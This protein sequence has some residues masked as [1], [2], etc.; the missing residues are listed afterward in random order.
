V[1]SQQPIRV[2]QVVGKMLGGGVE[3]VVMNYYRHTDRRIV[4]FD[5]IVDEDSTHVPTEEIESLGGRVIMVPPYQK[6]PAYLRALY[7]VFLDGQYRLVHSHINTLS[8]FPLWAAKRACVPVRIAHAQSTAGKGELKRNI[9]KYALRPFAKIYPT[10]LA[11]CGQYAGEWLFGKG[12]D[13]EIIYNAIELDTFAFSEDI[14]KAKRSELGIGDNTFVVGHIGRFVAQKNHSF[15]VDI[16]AELLKLKPGSLLLLEG[17]GELKEQ[18]KQKVVRLG[19]QESVMFLG[20]RNDVASLYQAFDM[21]LLPSLYEGLVMVGVEAQ[22]SGL[23]CFFSNR[24]SPE[25]KLTNDCYFLPLGDSVHD[26][27]QAINGF[28]LYDLNRENSINLFASYNIRH[29]A[30]TL[31]NYYMAAYEQYANEESQEV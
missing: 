27:V 31:Q 18:I 13:F 26:W 7:K 3:S 2:A 25:V 17:E 19:L 23:P 30:K 6:L 4:Q 29:A 14:R 5:F 8:V 28:S 15:L 12:A 22:R 11:A 24:I 9:M 1:L 10:R 16:F 21:L 20:R